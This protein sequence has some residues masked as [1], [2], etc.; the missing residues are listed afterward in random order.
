MWWSAR[1]TLRAAIPSA[2]TH[3]GHAGQLPHV[4]AHRFDEFWTPAEGD[5]TATGQLG[6][7]QGFHGVQVDVWTHS[8]GC[9]LRRR[10]KQLPAGCWACVSCLLRC[11]GS[12]GHTCGGGGSLQDEAP[13]RVAIA[14]WRRCTE[15]QR[16]SSSQVSL[17]MARS[18]WEPADACSEAGPE[19]GGLHGGGTV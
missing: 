12:G 4:Q 16:V 3:G 1:H 18:R 10:A 7:D 5:E 14:G 11:E 15:G 6:V 8:A 17:G 19:R 13:G 2:Q 9:Q